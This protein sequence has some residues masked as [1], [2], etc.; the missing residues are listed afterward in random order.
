MKIVQDLISKSASNRPG[1]RLNPTHITVHETGNTSKGADAAM[2]ARYI[3]GADARARKVSW[4]YTVDDKQI[5]QHVPD[6]ERAWHAGSGNSKSI[7]VEICVNSDGNFEK[8]KSNAA[9][10]L[11]N[12]MSKHNISLSNVVTHKYWTGK[13]C[14]ARLLK[15]WNAFKQ[16]ISN[17]DGKPINP[18]PAP[19]PPSGDAYV[20]SVQQWVVNYGY[21]IAVDGLKGPE[22]RKG[23]T[24]VYQNELNKQF[25]AG[26]AVD[27]IPGPKTYAAARNVRK[28]A[29]GNLTRVLQALLYLAGHN[30]GPFDGD[31]GNGTEKAVRAFQKAKGL[32]VDG[33]AGKNTWK[34]LL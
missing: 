18:K 26:L 8:A 32:G 17:V 1:D 33:I 34:A 25:G 13:N 5:I 12:L 3:K 24:K 23:I 20:R 28:G 21:K 14:P 4:H 30:P 15:E 10:L 16:L 27:G 6:N 2:H 9:W 31:F 11:R 29:K 19:T 7:G 22:T